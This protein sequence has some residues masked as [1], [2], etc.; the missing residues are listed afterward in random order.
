MKAKQ[1][2][3]PIA[4]AG[5]APT[6]VAVAE[7][8]GQNDLVWQ[9]FLRSSCSPCH[10]TCVYMLC[11]I[12]SMVSCAH[13]T[14]TDTTCCIHPVFLSLSRCTCVCVCLIYIYMYSNHVGMHPYYM[15]I[16]ICLLFLLPSYVHIYMY[17]LCYIHT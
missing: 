16:Y 8:S 15:Y 7:L 2:A 11:K 1:A 6:Q 4:P 9:E 17:I 5:G 13:N 3:E 12:C 14:H 10:T